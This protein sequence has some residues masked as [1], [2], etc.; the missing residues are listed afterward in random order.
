[1]SFVY[2]LNA[3]A[4]RQL[5]VKLAR[6]RPGAPLA[7]FTFD[8]FP[9]TAWT[10]GGPILERFDVKATYYAVGSFC[11][12]TVEAVEQYTLD[13]LRAVHAAGHEVGCHTFSHRHSPTVP[14]A[15]LVAD[16]ARNADFLR[17]VFGAD[18]APASFAYPYGDVS[19]RTKLLLARAFP[20]ARGIRPGVNGGLSDLAQL[21][22][23]PLEARSWTPEAVE[24]QV[25]AAK[26]AGAWIVFFS[27]DVSERPTPYGATPA[28]LEHALASVRDA[29]LTALPV[30]QALAAATL[31]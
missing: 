6:L 12:R 30:K 26:A 20:S 11:G 3:F 5:P 14:S 23:V 31:R 18:F 27:H 2:R 17:E 21:K 1:M 4:T 13:D 28:M 22:A 16:L 25:A 10:V 19:P 15:E 7:S 8:D 24:R 29:G 9:R